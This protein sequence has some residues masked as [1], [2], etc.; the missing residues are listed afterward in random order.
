MRP[1]LLDTLSVILPTP[2]QTSLLRA[3]LCTGDSG[4]QAWN[5]WQEQF[6][7][8]N[9]GCRDDRR[10]PKSLRPLLLNALRRNDVLVDR[11]LLTSLRRA[12]LTE[13][14]RSK[15]Y[16]RICQNVLSVLTSERVPAILLKGAAL[17][18]T[19]YG[20]PALRH[21]HDIDI[22][23]RDDDLPR[24]ASLLSPL[25]FRPLRERLSA[26]CEDVKLEHGSGLHS[27]CT[28][29]YFACPFTI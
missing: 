10:V 23:V 20:D 15:I 9:N 27:N 14:L 18:E 26:R 5:L 7:E 13:E 8:A 16:R 24:A 25:G 11:A 3:C 17:A 28:V 21:C 4:R 22:L 12:Y 6:G 1:A 29:V 2:E 19:I